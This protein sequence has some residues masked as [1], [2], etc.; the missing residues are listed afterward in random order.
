MKN[1]AIAF[2]TPLYVNLY[3]I[4]IIDRMVYVECNICTLCLLLFI[5][6]Y[7]FVCVVFKLVKHVV[8][9]LML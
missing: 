9:P 6:T 4:Y 7:L 5:I 1:C 8:T 2:G 3:D